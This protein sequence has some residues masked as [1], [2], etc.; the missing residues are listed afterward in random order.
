VAV[1][2]TGSDL[3]AVRARL[4]EAGCQPLDVAL[5]GRGVDLRAD[6]A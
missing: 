5:D 3:A 6:P 4:V 2:P 1:V